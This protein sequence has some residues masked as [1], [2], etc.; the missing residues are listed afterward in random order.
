MKKLFLSVCLAVGLAIAITGCSSAPKVNVYD[1]SVP[2]EQS[3]TLILWGTTV[4]NFDG[5]FVGNKPS[6]IGHNGFRPLHIIIPAGKHTFNIYAEYVVG[7][8]RILQVEYE[9]FT[10]DFL[11]GNTYAVQKKALTS[12]DGVSIID[13]T[14]LIKEFTPNSGGE[15]AT[16]LEGKWVSNNIKEDYI[17]SGNQFVTVNN[18]NYGFRGFFTIKGNKVQMSNVVYY[19]KNK[20]DVYP[21][22]GSYSLDYDGTTLTRTLLGNKE[23]V[24]KKSE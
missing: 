13:I 3:S 6:W 8:G 15:N 21:M 17:F 20:W 2:L 16:P 24:Y 7:S 14:E 4:M 5:N 11:P 18:G 9:P 1:N 19:N 12:D 23:A 10:V 22:V